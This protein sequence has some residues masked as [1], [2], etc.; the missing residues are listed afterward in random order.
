[1]INEPIP[2]HVFVSYSRADQTTVDTIIMALQNK[3]IT[4]WIDRTGLRTGTPN[5]N[6][7]IRTALRNSL[8]VLLMLGNRMRYLGNSRWQEI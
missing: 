3:G 5:W 7:A 4:F 1:M 6:T 8:A 2:Q